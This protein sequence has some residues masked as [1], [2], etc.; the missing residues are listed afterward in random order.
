MK[1]YDQIP[2]WLRAPRNS[3]R[4]VARTRTTIK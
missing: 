2:L 3:L 1:L 4:S